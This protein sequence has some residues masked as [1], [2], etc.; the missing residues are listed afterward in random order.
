MVSAQH[1]LLAVI[2]AQALDAMLMVAPLDTST[3]Q[4]HAQIAELVVER[5][6]VP[7]HAHKLAA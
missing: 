5:V 6:P 4:E 1:A 7:Q 2:P 3:P